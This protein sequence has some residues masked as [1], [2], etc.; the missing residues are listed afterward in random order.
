V[1][2][3]VVTA[4]RPAGLSQ[5][6][7]HAGDQHRFRAVEHL[8][9]ATAR[10]GTELLAPLHAGLALLAGPGEAGDRNRVLVLVT[11]GQ[12]GNEDQI[13]ADAAGLVESTRIHTVGIDQ[14]V[15]GGFLARLAALAAG[16]CELEES[17]DR[18][19]EAM[20]HIHR[21]IAAPVLTDLTIAADGLTL[22]DETRSP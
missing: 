1:A 13:L 4:E 3:V 22:L 12:V 16:R 10:G 19:D 6:L 8:A 21:R 5:G 15:N 7:V 11:D 20:E 9:S 18:L 14:A 2:R 17:E